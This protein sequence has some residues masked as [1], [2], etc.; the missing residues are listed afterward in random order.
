MADILRHTFV[1]PKADSPDTSLVSA[2]EWNDGHT[3][4]GGSNGQI[5]VADNTQAKG[6]KWVDGA[7]AYS[8][9]IGSGS[10]A[11]PLTLSLLNITCN[12]NISYVWSNSISFTISG[13]ISGQANFLANGV[14][15]SAILWSATSTS[16]QIAYTFAGNLAPGS[17]A[18]TMQLDAF[19]AATFSGVSNAVTVFTMGRM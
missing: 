12:S 4:T 18:L 8:T 7:I 17:Y 5:L 3:F 13:V 16:V 10:G 19:S 2:S 15:Q 6:V 11:D 9:F 14:S 1:S